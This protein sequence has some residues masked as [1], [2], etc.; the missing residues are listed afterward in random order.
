MNTRNRIFAS[1]IAATLA[2]GLAVPA[3]AQWNGG[4]ANQFR[5]QINQ[6]ERQ[7]DRSRG[8]SN[9]EAREL[10][11]QFDR[12]KAKYNQYAY[13]GFTANEVHTMRQM[14]GNV[15]RMAANQA[16]DTNNRYAYNDRRYY[17]DG[18]RW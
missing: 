15:Q 8:I 6:L 5:Q 7:V 13:N 16:R 17:N 14:I 4:W 18:R 10:G 3:S 11:W 2:M 9:R 1:A 12:L